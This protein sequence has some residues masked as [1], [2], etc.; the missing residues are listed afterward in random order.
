[1]VHRKQKQCAWE[2]CEVQWDAKGERGCGKKKWC[3]KHKLLVL[4]QYRKKYYQNN[5]TA[6]KR[7]QTEWN[8]GNR[9][10]Y[11]ECQA[12]YR[13]KN[14]ERIN[15]KARMGNRER[16]LECQAV[17]RD[18]N[19]ERINEKARKYYHA[20]KQERI[21]KYSTTKE[22]IKAKNLRHYRENRDAI[23]AK[24]RERWHKTKDLNKG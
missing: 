12:V 15:E 5:K 18:K 11:L 13:D 17:Y 4:Q 9:E 7:R 3:D 2:G 14:R 23:L 22:Y 16:Y 10:R 20:H 6:F 1:M 21:N 24:R 19:R 8:L